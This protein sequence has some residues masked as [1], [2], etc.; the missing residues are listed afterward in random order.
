MLTW[1]FSGLQPPSVFLVWF[2]CFFFK[3]PRTAFLSLLRIVWQ[4]EGEGGRQLSK[5]IG[6]DFRGSTSPAFPIMTIFTLFGGGQLYVQVF[7]KLDLGSYSSSVVF[8]K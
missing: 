1:V 8:Y 2:C 4:S 7:N 6:L 3:A 5:A